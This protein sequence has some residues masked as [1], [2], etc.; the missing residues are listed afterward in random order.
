MMMDR[1]RLNSKFNLPEGWY[2]E[3]DRGTRRVY[4][5]NVNTQERTWT[6]PSRA[7]AQEGPRGPL[8][9]LKIPADQASN[10]ARARDSPSFSSEAG[11]SSP[12]T[13]SCTIS[14]HAEQLGYKSAGGS[15]SSEEEA[16][17]IKAMDISDG[18]GTSTREQ[19]DREVEPG[20]NNKR[21]RAATDPR[22]RL[23]DMCIHD[24]YIH[25]FFIPQQ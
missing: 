22:V 17:A 3:F 23:P 21:A 16:A 18:V 15:K 20:T 8:G 11:L 25:S 7:D 6:E 10:A 4:F 1:V 13:E 19:K 2:A 9:G 12:L 5:W 14:T 24:A